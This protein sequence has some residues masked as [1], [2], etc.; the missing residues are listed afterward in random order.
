MTTA[1]TQRNHSLGNLALGL[2]LAGLLPI[3]G[4]AASIAAIICGRLAARER[5]P[6]AVQARLGFWLGIV[7]VAAPVVFLLIYCVVL[8]YPFPLHRYHGAR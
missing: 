2:G 3:P 4:L 5:G 7:Q 1:T 6:D 8:G